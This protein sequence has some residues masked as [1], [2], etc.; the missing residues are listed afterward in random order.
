MPELSV[1]IPG[2]QEQFHART[3]AD[4]LA[5]MRGD[6]EVIAVLDGHEPEPPLPEDSRLRVIR[7]AGVGQRAAVNIGA[8]ASRAKYLMKLDAHCSMAEG[9]DLQLIA[10]H[11]PGMT[12][13]PA[14]HNLHAFEW[15]CRQCCARERQGSRPAKCESCGGEEFEMH[16]VWMPRPGQPTVAWTFDRRLEFQ[17]WPEREQRSR[18]DL[19]E[20]MS[21]LGACMFLERERFWSLG[22]MDEGHGSWGQFGVEW[23]CKTW[24]SGGRLV[25]TRRTWFAHMFRCSN[26]NRNGES[27]WPYKITQAE[28]NAA[29]RYSRE[30]WH[31]DR[32]PLA[33][34]PLSWLVDRFRP[35][36]DWH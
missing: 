25:T 35:V 30:L 31:N 11:E 13:I 32:W 36:P 9:F 28:I 20:T 14:Q 18:G 26:F 23:A 12:L 22:G 1:I 15:C 33:T 17:Y 27:P 6:T 8:A 24:L 3:C 10:D 34:R 19:V 16:I 7:T 21:F 4:V 2:R 29:R 5:N